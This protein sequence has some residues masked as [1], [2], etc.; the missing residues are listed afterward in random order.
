MS[1]LLIV[2]SCKDTKHMLEYLYMH[3]QIFHEVV[4][5][6]DEEA[7]AADHKPAVDGI[8]LIPC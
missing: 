8:S 6:M 5:S 1:A 2:S 3:P 7:S 4:K